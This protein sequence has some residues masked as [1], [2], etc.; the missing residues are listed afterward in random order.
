MF[1]ISNNV[2]SSLHTYSRIFFITNESFAD[3][4]SVKDLKW[5]DRALVSCSPFNSILKWSNVPVNSDTQASLLNQREKKKKELEIAEK[6]KTHPHSNVCN[7]HTQAHAAKTIAQPNII[8]IKSNAGNMERATYNNERSRS[9][10][11]IWNV[12]YCI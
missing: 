4:L 12:F 2:N 5:T 9:H 10:N 8:S 6:L 3:Y 11:S 7:V 1:Y